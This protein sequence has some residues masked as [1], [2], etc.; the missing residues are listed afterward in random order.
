MQTAVDTFVDAVADPGREL[1]ATREVF[2]ALGRTEY[3]EGHR[4]DA[5]RP[6]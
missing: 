6:C 5:L 4:V 3:R 1:T 2:H